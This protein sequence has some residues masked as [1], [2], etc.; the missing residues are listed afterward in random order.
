[1][2]SALLGLI[3]SGVERNVV[4]AVGEEW[5]LSFGE[6]SLIAGRAIW[7]YA[8]KLF[9]PFNLTFLYPKWDIDVTVWWQR[10]TTHG[11]TRLVNWQLW[12]LAINLSAILLD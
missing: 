6:R 3:T 8:G 12:C 10:K 9:W 7:F 11:H 1:V 2:V 4:G 5:N